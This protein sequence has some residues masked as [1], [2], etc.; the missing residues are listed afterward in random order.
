MALESKKNKKLTR[1]D[2]IDKAVK[3]DLSRQDQIARQSRIISRLVTE[4]QMM[5]DLLGEIKAHDGNLVG[6][7]D[8]ASEVLAEIQRLRDAQREEDKE[9]ESKND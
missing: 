6:Y 2:I 1:A 9:T 4:N 3:L 7:R 5:M 8:K